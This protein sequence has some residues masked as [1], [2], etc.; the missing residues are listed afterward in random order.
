MYNRWGKAVIL[1]LVFLCACTSVPVPKETLVQAPAVLQTDSSLTTALKQDERPVVLGFSQV[2]AESRF[3]NANTKSIQDA[4]KQAGIDLK[5]SDA[6]QQQS[7][8]IEAIRSYIAAKVDVIAF[9]PVIETGWDNVLMEAKEAGIP[10]IITDRSVD[11]KDHSLYITLI[12]SNFVEE[13]RKAGKYVID[14]MRNVNRPIRI[15]E[16]RGTENSAPA[17]DRKRGFEEIIKDNPNMEIIASETGNFTREE[18]KEVM[19][20]FLKKHGRDIQVLFAHNDDMAFGAMEAMEEIGL[21]PGK[22]I[23]IVSVDGG[24]E[25]FQA[26]LD[27]RLNCTVE[28]NPLFG[29]LLMQAVRELMAG[30]NIPKRIIVKEGVFTQGTAAREIGN[31]KY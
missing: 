12:G 21:R 9:S 1:L 25:A 27:G 7:K 30:R 5:F 4:A 17:L 19:T 28:C 24:K 8:Q 29:P 23:V 11:V 31:R 13:G 22:D 2:G 6:E 14:K 10:V 3:R 15:A 18:G 16:I 20:R 26:M